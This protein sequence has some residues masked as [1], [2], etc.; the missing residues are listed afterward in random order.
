MTMNSE[1]GKIERVRARVRSWIAWLILGWLAAGCSPAPP[2]YEAMA[3]I[4]FYSPATDPKHEL[5]FLRA[6]RFL[7]EVFIRL[8]EFDLRALDADARKTQG[9][10]AKSQLFRQFVNAASARPVEQSRTIEICFLHSDPSVAATMANR[11]AEVYLSVK[12][13]EAYWM[14][15]AMPPKHPAP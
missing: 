9:A 11:I 10:D 14:Q 13:D 6:P 12:K 4:G 2:R 3:R 8:S 5:A 1:R 15:R 7:E